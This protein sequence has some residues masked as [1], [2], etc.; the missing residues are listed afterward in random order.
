MQERHSGNGPTQK[1]KEKQEKERKRI[2]QTGAGNRKDTPSMECGN[3]YAD[4]RALG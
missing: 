4:V 2:E 1:E 3:V